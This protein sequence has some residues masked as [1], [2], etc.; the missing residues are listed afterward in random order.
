MGIKSAILLGIVFPALSWNPVEKVD[1]W[2][3]TT[4]EP[5][6]INWYWKDSFSLEE[7]KKLKEWLISVTDATIS[8]LGR[9]P[10]ELD[11]YMHRRNN[12]REPVPWANTERY[13]GQ[14]VHFHV[15]PSFSSQDFLDDWTAPHEI[16]HLS[17]PYLG[18][19]QAW[20]AED[21]ASY[22]QYQVMEQLG[23]YSKSDVERRYDIKLERAIP[24]Y[25]KEQDMI[26][27]ARSLQQSH[28]YPQLYWGG[29]TYFMILDRRLSED[30]DTS[31]LQLVK[32]YQEC[33]RLGDDSL[34]ELLDSWDRIIGEPVCIELLHQYQTIPARDIIRALKDK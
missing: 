18:R 24:H 32:E 17:L 13:D 1:T 5:V 16:S 26:S 34:E 27:I 9:Y 6:E 8:T 10:F 12:S 11:F 22:M 23:I 4:S 28:L 29:A 25:Q 20:F 7:K 14:G 33:C 3:S 30:F 21:Y 19:K 31:L 2:G 15:D